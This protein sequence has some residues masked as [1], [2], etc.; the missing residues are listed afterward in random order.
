[1]HKGSV[2]CPML[3][4]CD[5]LGRVLWMNNSTRIVLRNPE[6]LSDAIIR[7]SSR[8]PATR[9]IEVAPLHFWLVWES[10]TSVLIG[11]QAVEVEPQETKDLLVLQRRLTGHLLQLL[12]LERRLF[13][14]AQQRR[15]RGGHPGADPR[16]RQAAASTRM[17]KA[18]T[19]IRNPPIVGHQRCSAT[20]RG[21]PS[22]RSLTLG[23]RSGSE[24]PDLPW[25]AGSALQ[26][27]AALAGHAHRRGS[28]GLWRPP[29]NQHPR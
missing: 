18:Y 13:A 12:G 21:I 29:L 17:A 8:P 20:L 24:D 25:I 28:G 9:E 4:E 5:F 15:G 19:G 22:D 14:T 2:T 3:L 1:M 11:A 10:P 27:G 7:R 26:P 6:H 16:H 23:T